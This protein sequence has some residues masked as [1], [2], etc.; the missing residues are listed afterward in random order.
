MSKTDS[1]QR[2]EDCLHHRICARQDIVIPEAQNLK[3][4]LLKEG[5][6]SRVVRCGLN[7]LAAVDLD[8]QLGFEAGEICDV[9][10]DRNLPP[11]A[12]IQELLAAQAPPQRPLRF[13]HFA[14]QR[15]CVGEG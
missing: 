14:A 13:G 1:V 12:D 15:A 11:E 4:L 2:L 9:R 10:T 6:T 8:D 3:P 5:I 7:M